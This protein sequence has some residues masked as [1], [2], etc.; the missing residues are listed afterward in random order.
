[1]HNTLHGGLKFNDAAN[2]ERSVES[3]RVTT[4]SDTDYVPSSMLTT[5]MALAISQLSSSFSLNTCSPPW[6]AVTRPPPYRRA[7]GC[8]FPPRKLLVARDLLSA[9]APRAGRH[10]NPQLRRTLSSSQKKSQHRDC[11]AGRRYTDLFR[12]RLCAA[13]DERCNQ[14]EASGDWL[15]HQ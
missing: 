11:I 15:M 10:P 4:A 7:R 12:L 1:M 14:E 2:L 5:M 6:T 9:P 8:S 13:D 3:Q